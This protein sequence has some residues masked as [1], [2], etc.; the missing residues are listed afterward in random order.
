VTQLE[1]IT[2][3]YTLQ[4]CQKNFIGPGIDVPAPDM[5]T[6]SREMSW[7]M[8]TYQQFNMADVDAMACVTGKPVSSGG[9]RGRT[10]ATGLGVFYGIREFLSY[11]EILEKT[12]LTP[13]FKDKEIVIQGFGNVGYW[14][15]KFCEE[16]GAKI[17]CISEYDGAIY[18]KNGLNVE[19]LFEYRR[20]TG[21]FANYPDG[22]LI[23]GK[24]ALEIPCDILIPAAKELVI[25]K[26]NADRINAKIIAEAANGPLNPEADEI[27]LK[28]G[29]VI[30]P[31]LL[32][33]AGG[34][35]VSY[36]EWLKNLSHVRFGRLNKKWEEQ[37]KRNL[38]GL[39]ESTG[40]KLTAQEKHIF[41]HGA[42]EVDLVRSGLD[43]TMTNACL[44]TRNTAIAQK[45]DHR[46]AAFYNA[47]MK[48]HAVYSDMGAMLR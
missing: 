37:N 7:V 33:N 41:I 42:D 38:L 5:G 15:A 47:I 27:L 36:F 22:T 24:K 32:L 8:N 9:I 4:L 40:R 26:A 1:N 25:T 19:K 2:R 45:T 39:F 20:A 12:G 13:G 44:E 3:A 43:D 21:T 34:V 18:N 10:E 29:A 30:I 17:I 28:K 46:T 48:I 23:D 31:D 11:E 35:T 16:A 6:G 14:G